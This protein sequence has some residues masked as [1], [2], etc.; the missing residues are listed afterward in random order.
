VAAPLFRQLLN[1]ADV[2]ADSSDSSAA[3]D[4]DDSTGSGSAAAGNVLPAMITSLLNAAAPAP[5]PV[6]PGRRPGRAAP[7]TPSAPAPP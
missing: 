4:S 1:L 3:A 6:A 2:A 7:S 5:A